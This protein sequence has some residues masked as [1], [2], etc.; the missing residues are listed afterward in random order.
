MDHFSILAVIGRGS[1]GKVML[2]QSKATGERIAIKAIPKSTLIKCQKVHTVIRE[3]M[4]LE[5]VSSPF[6]VQ[7][8]VAFQ[9][10]SKFYL[11]LEY[12]AG[13][14]L[15][16]R[17]S[18][19]GQAIRF[20]DARLYIAE[21]GFALDYLHRAGII[22]RDLKPE[23]VLINTD[24]HLKLTDFGLAKRLDVDETTATFCGTPEYITPEMLRQERYSYASDFWAL[25]VLAYELLF[26]D[27]PFS[28]PNRVRLYEMVLDKEPAW[29]R[30]ADP[31]HKDFL[32]KLLR[33]DPRERATFS[34]LRNH[35]FWTGLDL[36]A[37]FRR[38]VQPMYIPPND[39][40]VPGLN[41]ERE[42]TQEVQRDSFAAPVGDGGNFDFE[43]FSLP[44]DSL[45]AASPMAPRA[46]A[47]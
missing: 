30:R 21:L 4:I 40:L 46:L 26:N 22:Y 43:G 14:D 41:F 36:D 1:Y 23:N 10:P 28:A 20:H 2:C 32:S 19:D 18:A 6:I 44:G 7:L 8:K 5:K 31:V 16:R 17:M 13:G 25:G 3:R 33:K 11:G 27:H 15:F 35:A 47:Q 9:T 37:V 45:P 12:V 34:S 38:E 42:F 39:T 29:P 24:G